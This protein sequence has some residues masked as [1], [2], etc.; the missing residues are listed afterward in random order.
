MA[1]CEVCGKEMLTA[2]GCS[3]HEVFCSGRKYRR[4]RFGEE[5]WGAPGE[6][7]PDCGALYGHYHH[8]GCDVEEC[9]RCGGQMLGC[10][11]EDV[12]VMAKSTRSSGE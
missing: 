5:G 11:C 10:E 3:V 7:C 2:V 8:W 9:P 1:K 12:Y 4:L 6:R